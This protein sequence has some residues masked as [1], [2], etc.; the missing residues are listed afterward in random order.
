MLNSTRILLSYNKELNN[1]FISHN[2]IS[3][4]TQVISRLIYKIISFI[5][6]ISLNI[7]MVQVLS[8]NNSKD[9]NLWFIN[10][11]FNLFNK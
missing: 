7:N 1:K 6:G 4:Y 3:S 8:T 9:F 11:K 10:N 2:L 5:K